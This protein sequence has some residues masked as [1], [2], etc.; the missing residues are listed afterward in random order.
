MSENG[1]QAIAADAASALPAGLAEV[2]SLGACKNVFREMSGN[3]DTTLTAANALYRKYMQKTCSA[4]TYGLSAAGFIG[5]YS[6]NSLT[7]SFQVLVCGLCLAPPSLVSFS[8]SRNRS[9]WRSVSLTGVS[10]TTW[11]NKSPA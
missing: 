6:K 8:N 3:Q 2:I 7:L 1:A 11:Q 9:F 5:A 4:L 10:T